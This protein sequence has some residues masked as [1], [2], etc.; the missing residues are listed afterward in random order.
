MTMSEISMYENYKGKMRDLCD[1]HDLVYSIRLNTYPITFTVRPRQDVYAQM[2][3]LENVEVAGFRS[4]DASMTWR[5]FDGDLD[6]KVQGGTFTISKALRTKIE[7]ILMNMI[8]CWLQYFFREIIEKNILSSAFMPVIDDDADW[9]ENEEAALDEDDS[10]GNREVR[11]ATRIVRAAN[12]ATTAVLMR[13]MGVKYDRAL[14]LLEELE[15]LGVV[16]PADR[17][18]PREVLAVDEPDEAEG[19]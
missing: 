11:E 4:P 10:D 9:N 6:T 15:E 1:A 7:S 5:F 3:M 16:G 2:S 14:D 13:E 18:H 19:V 12:T 17:A 8:S